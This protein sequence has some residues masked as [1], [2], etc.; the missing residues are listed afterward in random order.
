MLTVVAGGSTSGSGPACECRFEG[1]GKLYVGP[2]GVPCLAVNR[3]GECVWDGSEFP[4]CEIG[5][6]SSCSSFCAQLLEVNRQADM[7]EFEAEAIGA[8]CD[9]YNCRSLARVSDRCFLNGRDVGAAPCDPNLL[10]EPS[11]PVEPTPGDS[12]CP[13]QDDLCSRS[14]I[15]EPGIYVDD[16][17]REYHP[18]PEGEWQGM[19]E[20][21]D[22][23]AI[24]DGEASCGLALACIDGLCGPCLADSD[25]AAGEACAL[26]H[27]VL[28]TNLGC[29]SYTDCEEGSLCL[30]SGYSSGYRGNHDMRAYCLSPNGGTPQRPEDLNR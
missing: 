24:C 6:E 5:S 11:T 21:I 12:Q 23:Q 13:A 18:R 3:I 7:Q 19:R 15:C 22:Q 27:C 14:G 8:V 16:A 9:T 20:R 2:L 29:R 30:L 25:C 26:D 1:G 10:V 28:E 4:G 17:M